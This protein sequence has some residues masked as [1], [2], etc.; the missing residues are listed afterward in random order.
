M[1]QTLISLI[2]N[3]QFPSSSISNGMKLKSSSRIC[4]K[5]LLIQLG[6]LDQMLLLVLQLWLTLG[7]MNQIRFPW[8]DKLLL[9]LCS[10]KSRW[11]CLKINRC[12]LFTILFTKHQ[13][14]DHP[15]QSLKFNTLLLMGMLWDDRVSTSL[16]PTDLRFSILLS[17]QRSRK[18][19]LVLESP[20]PTRCNSLNQNKWDR[21]L[22]L[23]LDLLSHNPQW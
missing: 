18:K 19:L 23:K 7:T 5:L 17:K 3:L 14:E 20:H 8:L 1:G 10:S 13:L 16:H 2:L 12:L 4:T 11:A 21:L 15:S 6:K 9:P 22:Q